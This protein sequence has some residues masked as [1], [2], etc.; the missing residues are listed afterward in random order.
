MKEGK[1]S[2]GLIQFPYHAYGPNSF[3][4]KKN[5]YGPNGIKLWT[6]KFNLR[7]KEY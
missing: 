4:K 6:S 1:M 3:N 2:I 5:A 7:E